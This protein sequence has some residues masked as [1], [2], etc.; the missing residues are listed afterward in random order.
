MLH[1]HVASVPA[2]TH[3]LYMFKIYC[4]PKRFFDVHGVQ[5]QRIYLCLLFHLC[6][7]GL[8]AYS[9][10]RSFPFQI[11]ARFTSGGGPGFAFLDI[12]PRQDARIQRLGRRRAN[13]SLASVVEAIEATKAIFFIY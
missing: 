5:V 3:F 13:A 2:Y 4:R 10:P 7:T 1:R 12:A 11:I 8:I 6:I 9:V